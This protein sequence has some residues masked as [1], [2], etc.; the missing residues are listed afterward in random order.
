MN[1]SSFSNHQ[2]WLNEKFAPELLEN[3]SDIVDC[4]MEQVAQ[5]EENIQGAK[6]G[7]FKIA[8]H[9][10][11]VGFLTYAIAQILDLAV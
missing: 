9:R 7:D 2:A 5:M 4:M 6:T 3:Q 11:E 8:I 1:Q 10:M